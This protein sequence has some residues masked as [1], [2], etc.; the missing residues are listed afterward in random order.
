MTLEFEN[1]T[2][3]THGQLSMIFHR[4]TTVSSAKSRM[5]ES[6]WSTMLFMNKKHTVGPRTVPWGPPEITSK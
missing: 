2:G 6:V 4:E 1:R 3:D 5:N